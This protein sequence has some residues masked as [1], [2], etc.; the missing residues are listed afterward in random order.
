MVPAPC[1]REASSLCTPAVIGDRAAGGGI[2][3]SQRAG[4]VGIN[5]VGRGIAPQ[6]D[7]APIR[8]EPVTTRGGRARYCKA[9][10]YRIL[11]ACPHSTEVRGFHGWVH[12]GRVV[13]KSQMGIGGYLIPSQQFAPWRRSYDAATR[14]AGC[15]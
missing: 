5:E 14:T 7:P 8:P 11:D 6:C 2:G 1:A 12:A 10:K 3:M 15:P 4:C 13:M 9:N